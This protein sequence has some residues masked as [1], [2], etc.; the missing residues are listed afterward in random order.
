[1]RHATIPSPLRTP[2]RR[3]GAP[4]RRVFA[5]LL[6][7]AFAWQTAGAA[8]ER[9]EI[10]IAGD[11]PVHAHG[12]DAGAPSHPGPVNDHQHPD[13]NRAAGMCGTCVVA[14][15]PVLAASPSGDLAGT[16][17]ATRAPRRL[18]SVVEAPDVPPP[19]L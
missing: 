8:I 9:C 5:A 16:V 3:I 19:K 4:A 1:M 15:L 10:V 17:A 12:G 6:A 18:P 11:A 14:P 2:I 7:G 13:A